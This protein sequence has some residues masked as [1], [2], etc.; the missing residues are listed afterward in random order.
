MHLCTCRNQIESI[1]SVDWH[2]AVFDE[3][4]KLKND[5]SATY[6]AALQ[7]HAVTNRMYGLSGTVMQVGYLSSGKH[8]VICC[9]CMG[10]GYGRQCDSVDCVAPALMRSSL[11]V[12]VLLVLLLQFA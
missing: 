6:K 11:R 2:V 3:A 4:H 10:T 7:L 8:V 5:D 1:T 9:Y 12:P